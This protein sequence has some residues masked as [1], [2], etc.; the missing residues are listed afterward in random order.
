MTSASWPMM[1]VV[2]AC[3]VETGMPKWAAV[4]RTDA[5]VASAAKPL[6][7][8]TFTI[9]CPI[10]LMIL[11]PPEA[12]PEASTRAQ[13]ILIHKGM[14]ASLPKFG[15][16]RKVSQDGR[17]SREPALVAAARASAMMP[18]VFWASFV[19]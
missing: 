6:M 2:M 19:P 5:P 11:Q 4:T 12:V 3:V 10:V 13:V 9:F 1:L 14:A 18:I 17:C 8:R 15:R 7:G 16:C